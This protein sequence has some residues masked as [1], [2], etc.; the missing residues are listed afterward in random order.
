MNLVEVGLVGERI[1]RA[2]AAEMIVVRA[3]RHPRLADPVVGVVAGKYATT[4]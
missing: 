4:L 2:A 1:A 3:N